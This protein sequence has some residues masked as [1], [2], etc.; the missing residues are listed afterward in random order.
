MKIQ[1]SVTVITGASSGIGKD[2]AV[3]LAT[4][5]ARTVLVARRRA[6]LETV[7]EQCAHHAPSLAIPCDVRDRA[8]VE[9]MIVQTHEHFGRVDILVNNAGYS[10]W[11]LAQ[12]TPIEEYEDMM[13]TNY[14]GAVYCTKAVL[15]ALLTQRS[16]HV[17]SVASI[18]GKVGTTH[19]THYCAT[20]FA[21]VGFTESL[22]HELQGT[23]VGVTLVNP[24]VIDTE[25]FHHES[26]ATFPEANRA[27]MMPVRPLTSAIIAAIER[28]RF[29]ITFPLY[30]VLAPLLRHLWPAAFRAIMRRYTR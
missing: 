2:L 15:P 24:G 14:F 9:A 1:D 19:H 12:H 28:D 27:R 30:F 3:C 4:K 5:G 11:T 7:R 8:Q 21:L 17:V 25:L 16:G 29:E 23:G 26:F 22:W 20:K 18:A 10:R 13:R 6:L